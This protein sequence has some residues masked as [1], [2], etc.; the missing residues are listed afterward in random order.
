VTSERGGV[1]RHALTDETMVGL[2]VLA[3]DGINNRLLL[4][5]STSSTLGP[6][7]SR[8]NGCP[9]GGEDGCSVIRRSAQG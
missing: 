9:G 6:L 7:A 1:I 3:L 8:H 2:G 5:K 4:L